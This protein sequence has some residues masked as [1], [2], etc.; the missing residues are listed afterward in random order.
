[1][2]LVL[3]PP[4]NAF[5]ER[6]FPPIAT[7]PIKPLLGLCP[8]PP[9]KPGTGAEFPFNAAIGGCGVGAADVH[10]SVDSRSEPEPVGRLIPSMDAR[11]ELPDPG[12][13]PIVAPPMTPPPMALLCPPG[14]RL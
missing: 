3:P 2:S 8:P 4:P 10:I 5:E 14:A 1:M 7:P 6:W 11:A 12:M 13:P 9:I